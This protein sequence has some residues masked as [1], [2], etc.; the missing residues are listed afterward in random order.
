MSKDDVMLKL[1]DIFRDTF[2]DDE[3]EVTPGTSRDDVDGWDSLGHIRI[4]SSVEEEFG[5]RFDLEEV[6]E[7]T[8]AGQLA[9]KLLKKK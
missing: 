2:D 3:L 1:A 5:I 8:T 9:D 4:L 7:I 6:E